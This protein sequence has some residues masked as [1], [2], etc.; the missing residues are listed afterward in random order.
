[1]SWQDDAACRDMPHS[2]FFARQDLNAYTGEVEEGIAAAKAI[3][4]QC[5]VQLECLEFQLNEVN[6]AS[7]FGIW[8]GTEREERKA[9]RAE[10]VSK[11]SSS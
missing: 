8:G 4:A 5:P 9:I 3:C 1:M 10:I 7:D 2:I 6:Y 11:L